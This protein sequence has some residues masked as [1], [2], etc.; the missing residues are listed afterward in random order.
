M[1]AP[2]TLS[3]QLPNPLPD[4]RR[5]AR[6]ARRTAIVIT[7]AGITIFLLLAGLLAFVLLAS[8]NDGEPPTPTEPA[9]QTTTSTP[10]QTTT[11]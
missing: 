2:Q 9:T 6:I 5:K 10:A 1:D 11:R 7:A 4:R 8:T 3:Y